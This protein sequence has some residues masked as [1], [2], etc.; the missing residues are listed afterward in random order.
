MERVVLHSDINSCYVSIE[1]LERPKLRGKPVAV[2]GDPA[3]RHGIILTASPEGKRCGLRAG[4]AI[5]QARQLCPELVLLPPHYDKYVQFARAAQELYADFTDL[6][7]PF[8]LDESWLD[9]TGCVAHRDGHLAAEEIRRRMKK[10]LGV[11]VSVGVS[12]NKI[13]AKL[14]SDYKKPDAVTDIRRDNFRDLVWPLPVRALLFVGPATERRLHALGIRRI[15]ELAAAD[16]DTLRLRLGKN[17]LSLQAAAAGHDISPV[18][19]WGDW[20]PLK[21]ISHSVTPPRDLE[22]EDEARALLLQLVEAVAGRLRGAGFKAALAEVSVRGADNLQ[23]SSHQAALPQPIDLTRTLY[24]TALQL[25]REMHRWPRALRGL[26]FRV[27]DL[28]A[29]DAP[30]Q[31]NLFDDE[32]QRQRLQRLDKAVDGIR[33]RF[34]ESAIRYLGSAADPRGFTAFGWH[35]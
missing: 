33:A 26:G 22:N 6:R 16:P 31:P 32:R 23:W 2:A 1:L 13:F 3:E 5:W 4:M 19:R 14:G 7:E 35:T 27:G 12:W 20:T 24:E 34:G 10:E 8:G 17:G 11:T 28:R 9:L 25:F 18:S 30:W 29:A 15:G 21:S